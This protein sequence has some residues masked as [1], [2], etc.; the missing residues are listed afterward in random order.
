MTI[1]SKGYGGSAQYVDSKDAAVWSPHSGS[2]PH[3]ISGLGATVTSTVNRTV[4]ID[5]GKAQGWGILDEVTLAEV[6]TLDTASVTTP[7]WDAIVLHRDWQHVGPPKGRSTLAVV[8]GTTNSATPVY[9][10][11]LELDP[12]TVADQVLWLVPVTNTG[13]G[14]PVPAFAYAAGSP[15]YVPSTGGYPLDP[16]RFDYGQLIVQFQPAGIQNDMLLRRGGLGSE[17]FDSMTAPQWVYPALAG[18]LAAYTNDQKL[19]MAV[20]GKELVVAGEIVRGTPGAAF[21]I[22]GGVGGDWDICTV[23][24]ALR[25]KATRF[26]AS[27]AREANL[28]YR[29]DAVDGKL[30]VRVYT[31]STLFLFL[32]GVRFPI[33]S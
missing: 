5:V 19:R 27:T 4:Q 20:V 13:A 24:T 15:L 6:L 3:L 31:N 12:G 22:G 11:T 32:D 1:V 8:K 23:P 9:P 14:T 30:K 18:G 33:D 7:R 29:F 2:A 17:T 16:T 10:S 26:H 28:E 25:P 21:T